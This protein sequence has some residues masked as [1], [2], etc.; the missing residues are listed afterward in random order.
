ML[1]THNMKVNWPK[2]LVTDLLKRD[3]LLA[4]R[5]EMIFP[6]YNTGEMKANQPDTRTFVDL[7]SL[8]VQYCLSACKQ[9]TFQCFRSRC[10]VGF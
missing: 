2:V 5:E 9:Q 7:A 8:S 4:K 1:K 3:T 6:S 10:L